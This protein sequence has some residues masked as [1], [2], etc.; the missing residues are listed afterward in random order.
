MALCLGERWSEA[1]AA[2]RACTDEYMRLNSMAAAATTAAA[3]G[4][5]VQLPAGV[6]ARQLRVEV[7]SVFVCK[8]TSS[9]ATLLCV[10]H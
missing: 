8:T 5:V 7:R 3:A 6:S 9:C 4:T 1:A 2:L 10:L